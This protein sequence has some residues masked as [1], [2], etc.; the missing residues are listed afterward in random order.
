MNRKQ[1]PP[2]PPPPPQFTYKSVMCVLT[3]YKSNNDIT[4]Q[5]IKMQRMQKV[6]IYTGKFGFH[7]ENERKHKKRNRGRSS[8]CAAKKRNG[9]FRCV[10]R[11]LSVSES[12]HRESEQLANEGTSVNEGWKVVSIYLCVFYWYFWRA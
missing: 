8:L 2:L 12:V 9:K 6:N 11:G 3:Q 7:K 10:M 5:H 4:I 1:S